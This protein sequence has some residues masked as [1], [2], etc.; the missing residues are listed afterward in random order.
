MGE[1]F[2]GWRRKAGLVTLAMACLLTIAWMRSYVRVNLLILDD[3]DTTYQSLSTMFGGIQWTRWTSEVGH[4]IKPNDPDFFRQLDVWS[5]KV[6]W[7]W[8]YGGFDFV[9]VDMRGSDQIVRGEVPYWSLVLPLTLLSASLIL[10]KPRKAK[11][12][13][14]STP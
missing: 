6:V 3:K 12:A 1:F 10:V 2:K 14:G 4:G 5:F 9:K 7:R 8:N 11:A 13:T